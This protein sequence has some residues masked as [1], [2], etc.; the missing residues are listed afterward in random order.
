M[1]NRPYISR[2]SAIAV[3]IIPVATDAGRGLGIVQ[4]RQVE[5]LERAATDIVEPI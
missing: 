5:T 2:K 1:G 4:N 3:S